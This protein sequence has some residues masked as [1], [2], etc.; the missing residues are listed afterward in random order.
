MD[1]RN[2]TD[3]LP[4]PEL[5]AWMD[6]RGMQQQEL[7]RILKVSGASISYYLS[8][9]TPWPTDIALR[10]SVLTAIPVERFVNRETSRLLKLWGERST[11]TQSD[12]KDSSNVA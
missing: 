10:V 8:A 3:K 12:D 9:V 7:A 4:F 2:A 1:S 5:R 6:E 11:A